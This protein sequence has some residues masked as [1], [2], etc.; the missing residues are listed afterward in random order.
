[1]TPAD[2]A[3][4][5]SSTR[6]YGAEWRRI[7]AEVFALWHIPPGIAKAMHVHH[8]PRWPTLGRDHRAYCLLPAPGP[9]HSRNTIRET[10]RGVRAAWP[11]AVPAA[12]ELFAP[13]DLVQP[14]R[15]DPED[16]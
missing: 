7:R 2:R 11:D 9:D 8:H 13:C 4:P 10:R 12:G 15:F 1:M 5:P 16:W 14:R 6:G 3:R